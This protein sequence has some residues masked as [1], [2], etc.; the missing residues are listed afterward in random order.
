MSC[1]S[2]LVSALGYE[3]SLLWGVDPEMQVEEIQ[4]KNDWFVNLFVV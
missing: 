3:K 1:S 2:V 4:S